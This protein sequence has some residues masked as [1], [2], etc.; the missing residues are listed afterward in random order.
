M[1]ADI[2]WR[3][4]VPFPDSCTQRRTP[5][6]LGSDDRYGVKNV[7]TATIEPNEIDSMPSGIR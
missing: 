6:S 5:Y 7:R 3:R 1:R 2:D 4:L